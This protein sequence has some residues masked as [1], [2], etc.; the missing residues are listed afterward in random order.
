MTSPKVPP[1]V[2]CTSLSASVLRSETLFSSPPPTPLFSSLGACQ[3][4]IVVQYNLE[5]IISCGLQLY[6]I[7]II[8]S[9]ISVWGRPTYNIF[10]YDS[11]MRLAN[12]R[13][14]TQSDKQTGRQ[15]GRKA[16]RQGGREAGRQR[17]VRKKIAY[18]RVHG[19]ISCPRWH[20][21]AHVRHTHETPQVPHA[22]R[23]SGFGP[24]RAQGVR[25]GQRHSLKR[26][27]S[28]FFIPT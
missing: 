3:L 14:D 7:F 21:R 18:V 9:V 6:I 16:D 19:R 23:G 13:T 8:R 12:G 24:R 27:D 25:R 20:E 5:N 17:H 10:I 11:K 15:G 4:V 22:K 2:H 26:P 1:I 28:H